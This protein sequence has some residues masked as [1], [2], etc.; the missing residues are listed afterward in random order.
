MYT[1]VHRVLNTVAVTTEIL[2]EHIT[3]KT[4]II[5]FGVV[6]DCQCVCENCYAKKGSKCLTINGKISPEITSSNI[7]LCTCIDYSLN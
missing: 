4:Q 6:S 3:I 5:F 2:P 7:I 1:A